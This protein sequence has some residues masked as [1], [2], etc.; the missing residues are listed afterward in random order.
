MSKKERI[1]LIEKFYNE[2]D[3]KITLSIESVDDVNKKK[4]QRFDAI[5][6]IL[7]CPESL[8]ENTITNLEAIK[9]RDMLDEFIDS[10]NISKSIVKDASKNKP[11]KGMKSRW[12]VKRKRNIDCNNPKGFSQ[13]QYCKRKKRGGKYK[14][15]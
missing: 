6:I 12:S 8:S 5:K 13:K 10:N 2:L 7:E 11:R 15:K 3:N 14:D 1:K 4:K 9:M